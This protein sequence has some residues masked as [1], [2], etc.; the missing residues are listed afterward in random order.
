MSA[1]K[2][3]LEKHAPMTTVQRYSIYTCTNAHE[4]VEVCVSG[5]GFL[6]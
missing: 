2:V 5:D 3:L 6:R 4:C 1:V